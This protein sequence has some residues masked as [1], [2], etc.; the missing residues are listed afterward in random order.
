MSDVATVYEYTDYGA[1]TLFFPEDTPVNGWW[2]SEVTLA[3]ALPLDVQNKLI[4]KAVLLN[5]GDEAFGEAV[6]EYLGKEPAM[7]IAVK[8]MDASAHSVLRPNSGPTR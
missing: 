3:D 5:K 6:R 2:E 7:F 4:T 8:N 1:D